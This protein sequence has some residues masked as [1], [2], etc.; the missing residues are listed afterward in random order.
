MKILSFGEV[1]WDLFPD[2]EYIGGA[3]FNFSAN[4][5]ILGA[6]SY[7]L[8]CVGNDKLGD[9]AI[10]EFKKELEKTEDS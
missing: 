1:I 6:D 4:L 3:V 5:S 10:E 9:L 7:L 8:T 2:K